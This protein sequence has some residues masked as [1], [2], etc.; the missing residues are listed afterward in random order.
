MHSL[1]HLGLIMKVQKRLSFFVTAACLIFHSTVSGRPIPALSVAKAIVWHDSPIERRSDG[2]YD[3]PWVLDNTGGD[4]TLWQVHN[5][6][7]V[8]GP[9]HVPPQQ[10]I[11]PDVS[12]SQAHPHINNRHWDAAQPQGT[13]SV[14]PVSFPHLGSHQH[15]SLPQSD[16][17]LMLPTPQ[18]QGKALWQ[19]H[20]DHNG[21]SGHPTAVNHDWPIV[22][23]PLVPHNWE[24]GHSPSSLQHP[25]HAHLQH[26][27]THV[28]ASLSQADPHNHLSADQPSFGY[29]PSLPQ[30]EAHPQCDRQQKRYATA[31]RKKEYE[32]MLAGYELDLSDQVPRD[33]AKAKQEKW[34]KE[35][36]EAHPDR[37]RRDQ[38]MLKERQE[39]WESPDNGFSN[40]QVETLKLGFTRDR[41]MSTPIKRPGNPAKIQA[42]RKWRFY[43][44]LQDK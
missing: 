20:S 27:P 14:E 25:D 32:K 17:S 1:G 3:W 38:A 31:K 21:F 2:T 44:S 19:T 39:I 34:W 4:G 36:E 33:L 30:L 18:T 22:T 26:Q 15:E 29:L 28:D 6:P 42:M 40:T 9:N 23:G 43:T 10:Q 13:S 7:I 11:H 12:F 16:G 24:P 8:A 41:L 35:Q 37:Y 5:W